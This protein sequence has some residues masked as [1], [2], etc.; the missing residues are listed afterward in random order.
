MRRD[1][2]CLLGMLSLLVVVAPLAAQPV[3][4]I[5]GAST[6]VIVV[7]K[8]TE[9]TLSGENIGDGNRILVVGEA[10]VKVDLPKPTTQPATTQPTTRPVEAVKIN[11][12]E[13]KVVATVS[14]DA[15]RG[16]REIRVVTPNG[17]TKPFLFYVEDFAAVAEKEPNN[18]IAEAQMVRLPAIIVGTIHQPT[19]SDY[20]RF[21]G[22]K[23]QRLIF[24]VIAARNGSKLDSTLSLYN[25]QG[26]EV[27]HDEDTNG[28]DS[29]IDYTVPADG[30]Y[31]LHIRDLR[32]QGGGDFT[33]RIKA[34]EIPYVDVIYPLGGKR[35]QEISL[36]LIG[37]NLDKPRMSMMLDGPMGKRDVMAATSKGVSNARSFEVGDLQETFEAEPN[38]GV[39]K[40]T[41][42]TMPIVVN[43]RINQAGDVDSFKVRVSAT[44]PVVCEV[45]AQRYGSPLD[46]LLSVSDDKGNILQR[47]DDAMGA[48]ARIEMKF[49]TDKDYIISVTDLLGRGGSNY[50]YRLQITPVAAEQPDFEVVF[51][52]EMPRVGRGSQMK[53]WC[54]VKRKGGFDGDV[55]VALMDMP[56]GIYCEPLLLKQKE[57]NSGLMAIS[58]APDAPLGMFPL[59]LIASGKVGDRIISRQLLPKGLSR[60]APEVYLAVLDAS[61]FAVIRLGDPAG[62]DPKKTAAEIAELQK[63]LE[64]QTPEL[65]AAQAKWESETVAK[66]QWQ[67]LEYTAL[68]ARFGSKLTKQPDGAI[69]SEGLNP[70][71]EVYNITA[72]SK[73]KNITAFKLEVIADDNK[74]PGRADDGNFVLSDLEVYAAPAGGESQRTLVD[75]K[76]AKVDFVQAGFDVN[77]TLNT[78]EPGHQSGWAVHPQVAQS[79]W[80]VW[81]FNKAV[82]NEAGTTL[83]F[84]INHHY[85]NGKFLLR[86]FR[87]LVSDKENPEGG[88]SLS[89][90]LLAV[91]TTPAQKRDAEQKKTIAA[92]YRSIAP[93]LKETRERLT[94]LQGASSPFPPVVVGN[95]TTNVMVTV[96][97]N[98]FEGDINLSLEGFS[99]GL[100]P[101]TNEPPNINKNLDFKPVTIKG[102]D[103]QGVINLKT[104][105]KTDHATRTLVVKAE[106]MVNGVGYVEYSPL[107]PLTVK[108]AP[109]APPK[110]AP[111]PKAEAPKPEAKKVEPPKAEAKKPDAAK[112]DAAKAD[113][114]KPDAK[115]VEAAKPDAKKVDAPKPPAA[116]KKEPAK[117]DAVKPDAAKP[118]A[119]KPDAA[120][121]DAAKPDAAKP[122]AAQ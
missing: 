78:R 62:N 22:R 122:P 111:A 53:L 58:A 45:F 86:K 114:P 12:K 17:I 69:L 57:A 82:A 108:D 103:T 30:Q 109:P 70:P 107:F 106:A 121:P 116:E 28:L 11:P 24:E 74:G 81:N 3:P 46:A 96:A 115:K 21:E 117:P 40:A 7:G 72:K 101:K 15:S 110:P 52:P 43:G 93:E 34:G 23:G 37:R 65:D 88:F 35:G 120:K 56:A 26:R 49:E 112:P 42:T 13:L 85:G 10:G 84:T 2:Y 1:F 50:P 25:A 92:H 87:I 76:S 66:N 14:G 119:A 33:Y 102:K 29:L 94:F 118:D 73:L 60:S 68:V 80:G 5:T 91:L 41:P 36:D 83:S 79:H 38:D 20:F 99:S 55:V 95:G 48:D 113:A 59:H 51:L 105:G 32:Y 27:A 98:G 54:Q 39:A 4:N 61:P 6:D 90:N 63:K 47:N 77:M 104:S 97:R 64:T 18:S 100:D 75:L 71:Q 44:Q 16:A 9:I 67:P 8:T 89:D 31:V 19:E